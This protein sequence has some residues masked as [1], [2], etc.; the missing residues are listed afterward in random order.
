MCNSLGINVFNHFFMRTVTCRRADRLEIDCHWRDS[1]AWLAALFAS[2]SVQVV[3][4]Q[5]GAYT[6]FE[7]DL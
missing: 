1:I 6:N 4:E 5:T 2:S 3:E 7:I